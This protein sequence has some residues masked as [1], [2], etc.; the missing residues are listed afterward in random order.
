MVA[1]ENLQ[2]LF[3]DQFVGLSEIH[4]GE[5]F[6]FQPSDFGMFQGLRLAGE[7]EAS[8]RDQFNVPGRAGVDHRRESGTDGNPAS[9]FFLDFP[10]QTAFVAFA[11]MHLSARK[12]P[13]PRHRLAFG[14]PGQKKFPGSLDE[15]ASDGD[16]GH[17]RRLAKGLWLCNRG[18]AIR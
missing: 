12:L 15:G 13:L 8:E 6:R 14:T 16:G 3:D 5:A 4:S 2:I 9:Q 18:L 1:I 11:G 10:L 7:E 17:G